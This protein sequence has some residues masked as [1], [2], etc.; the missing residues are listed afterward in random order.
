MGFY[1]C[2]YVMQCT[3]LKKEGLEAE[4]N[5]FY[6]IVLQLETSRNPKQKNFFITENFTYQNNRDVNLDDAQINKQHPGFGLL[7]IM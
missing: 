1:K 7:N 5:P 6:S 4:K 2:S 3:R